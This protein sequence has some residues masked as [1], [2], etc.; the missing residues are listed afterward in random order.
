MKA[1]PT[2]FMRAGID[3]KPFLNGGKPTLDEMTEMVHDA[4]EKIAAD[5]AV[6][7][8]EMKSFRTGRGAS[9]G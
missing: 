3:V 4:A 8:E 2:E 6:L 1:L 5:S 9:R 7:A